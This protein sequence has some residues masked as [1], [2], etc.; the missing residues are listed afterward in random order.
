[1]APGL[2]SNKSTTFS[3]ILTLIALIVQSITAKTNRSRLCH[4]PDGHPRLRRICSHRQ[5]RRCLRILSTQGAVCL[6]VLPRN[7]RLRSRQNA[8]WLAINSSATSKRN[9]RSP[10]ASKQRSSPPPIRSP[11]TSTSPPRYVP[12]TAVAGDFYDFPRNRPNAGRLAHRR[13]IRPRCPRRVDRLHGQA[14]S[15][16]RSAPTQPNPQLSYPE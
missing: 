7:S 3:V 13:C 2:F 10:S 14:S 1:M 15:H 6:R 11:L 5:H 9:S 8:V 12:M 16:R 4:R